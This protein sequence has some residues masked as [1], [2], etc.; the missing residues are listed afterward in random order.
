MRLCEEEKE[1]QRESASLSHH[2]RLLLSSSPSS[3]S[4]RK[5]RRYFHIKS[6]EQWMWKWRQDFK[7]N[8]FQISSWHFPMR[9]IFV[10][11]QI[12]IK[13][14]L[15]QPYLLGRCLC[16]AHNRN[17]EGV[18]VSWTENNSMLTFHTG[19]WKIILYTFLKT[20]LGI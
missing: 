2:C 1:R 10:A 16:L 3:L 14:F 20:S 13:R 9:K 17:T 19:K 6:R 11:T 5:W 18:I 15:A 7:N 8:P 4:S 12:D